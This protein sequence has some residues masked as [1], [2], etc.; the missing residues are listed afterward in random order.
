MTT[1]KKCKIIIDQNSCIFVMCVWEKVIFRNT[2]VEFQITSISDHLN[3]KLL[4]NQIHES[5]YI[6]PSIPFYLSHFR[7]FFF[8]IICHFKIFMMH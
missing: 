8:H 5:K 2:Q 3:L 4:S 7:I 1:T 6:A